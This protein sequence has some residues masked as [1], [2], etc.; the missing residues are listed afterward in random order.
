MA[1]VTFDHDVRLLPVAC[2]YM[3]ILHH[4]FAFLETEKCEQLLRRRGAEWK[5]RRFEEFESPTRSNP[6][7]G[8]LSVSCYVSRYQGIR[9]LVLNAAAFEVY[10][11]C[12]IVYSVCRQKEVPQKE[13]A[14]E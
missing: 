9:E 13:K 14:S 7:V 10:S 6:A 12:T 4:S 3:C 8:N 2:Q 11:T 5:R 1:V